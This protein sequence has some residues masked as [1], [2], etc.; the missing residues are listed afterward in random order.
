M[1]LVAGIS[2]GGLPAFIGDL[3]TSW[4]VPVAVD[5]PTQPEQAIHPSEDGY[6]AAS[7]AQKLIIVRHYFLLAWAG[8]Q[9]NAQRIVLGLEA[10]LPEEFD[11]ISDFSLIFE[12]LQTCAEDSEMIALV[13]GN[14]I[15]QPFGIRTRGFEMDG[16]RIYL[17]GSGGSEFFEYLISH[18]ETLPHEDEDS[19]L[20]RALALRFAARSLAIQWITGEG[21]DASWGGGFEVVYPGPSGFQKIDRI[22]FRAWKIDDA[23][24]YVN[25]GRSFF[26]RYYGKDLY[27]SVFNPD[28][29][30]YLVSSPIG[31]HV[32]P[33]PFEVVP[34]AY[35]VDMFLHEPTGYLVEFVRFQPDEQPANEF[36]ELSNGILTG[37]SMDKSYVE[38]CVCSAIKEAGNGNIFREFKY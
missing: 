2:L 5:L 21:L 15:V 22:L 24:D 3:L 33:P 19:I 16:R 23:G 14:G 38:R 28:E 34:A 29:R 31:A 17:M 13:I 1:T 12:L 6:Y 8:S 4:R 30:T 20:S 10:L 37:W 25:S 26:V 35:I 36:V 32:A 18:P 27:L 9:S 7:L 11:Q